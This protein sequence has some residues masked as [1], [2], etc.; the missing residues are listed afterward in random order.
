MRTLNYRPDLQELR[1]IAVFAVIGFH[2]FP[3][4]FQ[5]GF[6][7]VDFF[8]AFWLLNFSNHL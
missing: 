6:V 8:C 1:A 2:Y 3:N 7:G 5:G 4:V